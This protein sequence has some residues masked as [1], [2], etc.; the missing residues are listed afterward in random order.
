MLVP[1]L[2]LCGDEEGGFLLGLG[3]EAEAELL[4]EAPGL[5]PACVAGI[6]AFWRE[7]RGRSAAG[8]GRRRGEGAE[9]GP[10][11]PVPLRLRARARALRRRSLNGIR[12][13]RRMLALKGL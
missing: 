6:A 8:G 9:G 12:G 2:A 7:R 11:R 10:R 1:I 4:A 13:R 5:I 3:P